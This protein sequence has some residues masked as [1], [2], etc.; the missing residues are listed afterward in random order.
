M[1]PLSVPNLA[2][3]EWQYV[4]ECIETNWVSSVG[5]YVNRFEEECARFSGVKYGVATSNGTSAL[6]IALQLVGVK[7]GT[8]VI[9]PNITFIA[10]ANS[11]AYTGATPV[12]IDI[13][14]RTWQMDL[15]LLEAFL[16]KEAGNGTI[17]TIQAIMPVH[18]LGNMCN[19]D[20]LMA[21]SAQYGIAV[22]EDA[23]ESM[24]STFNGRPAGSFGV[25]GCLSFNGNKI[26]TTGGGGMIL[27]N[28][29]A[30]A[31]HAKHLTTQAKTDPIEYFHDETGYNYRLVN[32]L[33]AMGVAQIEQ[34]P[35][36]LA[37][38]Q[39]V[40]ARYRA[41][42]AG[43]GDIRF[44]E[45]EEGVSHNEWL[46]TIRTGRSRELLAHLRAQQV[47]SRPFW[48]PMNQ[49]PMYVDHVYIQRNDLARV[50]HQE[51]LSIPC[52]SNITDEEQNT[53]ISLIREFFAA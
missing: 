30:L 51:C 28:D 40:A 9:V 53:V 14:A 31:K 44:Q 15:D 22:V 13:D 38:K 33:A 50:I 41:E 20:R 46:F 23:T 47:E 1:I 27:T 42:L 3:N 36:F 29:E 49:L 45:K 43:V 12:F 17:D 25:L 26:M 21:L 8:R 2:G 4:K 39:E 5:A 7:A 10:S 24:G 35:A 16:Q 52:S 34:M 48:T 37:R 11:V 19:M 6:H 32:I 18:V